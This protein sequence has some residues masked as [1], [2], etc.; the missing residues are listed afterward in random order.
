MQPFCLMGPPPPPSSFLMS[1]ALGL[2]VCLESARHMS[3]INHIVLFVFVY[4]SVALSVACAAGRTKRHLSMSGIN[5]SMA[6]AS[7]ASCSFSSLSDHVWVICGVCALMHLNSPSI[8]FHRL[9]STTAD[10]KS[11]R[12]SPALQSPE[13]I[14]FRNFL[15]YIE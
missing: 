5:V 3:K 8:P 13:T 1:A 12:R 11:L 10:L 9:C 6:T 7:S 2:Y 15:N 14:P 4:V